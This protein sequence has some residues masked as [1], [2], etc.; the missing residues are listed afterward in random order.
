VCPL[1]WRSGSVQAKPKAGIK[2]GKVVSG[3][4]VS[5]D[6]QDWIRAQ[7]K[8]RQLWLPVLGS[9]GEVLFEQVEQAPSSP[10]TTFRR[11]KFRCI[12]KVGGVV[13]RASANFDDKLQP[14]GGVRCGKEVRTCQMWSLSNRCVCVCARARVCVRLLTRC[15]CVLLVV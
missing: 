15:V 7:H 8:T 3:H 5:V 14:K 2:A 10:T 12:A 9:D 1:D 11:G 6:R 13:F 4:F